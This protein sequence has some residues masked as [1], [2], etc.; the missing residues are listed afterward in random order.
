L[1]LSYGES[2]RL[3]LR[4][5]GLLSSHIGIRVEVPELVNISSH[6]MILLKLID[7]HTNIMISDVACDYI[8]YEIGELSSD[9]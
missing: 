7:A 3:E 1:A 9:E 8:Q 5:M 4:I 6:S 2:S